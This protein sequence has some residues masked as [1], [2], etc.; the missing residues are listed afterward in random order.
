MVASVA[1]FA[2]TDVDRVIKYAGDVNGVQGYLKLTAFNSTTSMD[3][4]VLSE[5][6]GTTATISWSLGKWNSVDGWPTSATF[7]EQRLLMA[8]T[9]TDPQ[10]W[11]G[12]FL[13]APADFVGDD[14]TANDDSYS[15]KVR[16]EKINVI[17]W[18][19][20]LD[21]LLI[22]TSGEEFK[23]LGPAETTIG[24]VYRPLIQGQTKH[25]TGGVPPLVIEDVLMYMQW[26]DRRLYTLEFK[27]DKDAGRLGGQDLTFISRHLIPSGTKI[28]RLAYEEQPNNVVWAV[29][30]DGVM[31]SMLYF[32]EQEVLG[33]SQHTTVNGLFEEVMC[34]PNVANGVTD[35]YV[36]VKRTV[37]SVTKRY[38]EYFDRTLY[39]DSGLSGTLSP[40]GNVI[41]GLNHLIGEDVV[42]NGDGGA[43]AAV[44]VDAFGQVTMANDATTI[45]AG[46]SFVPTVI[47]LEPYTPSTSVS[48]DQPIGR[49]KKY[50]PLL[51]RTLNTKSLTVNGNTQPARL[52]S[53]LM[54]TPPPGLEIQDWWLSE[55]GYKT[56]SSL[57]ITQPLPL[58][59]HVL[60][61]SGTMTI[62]DK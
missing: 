27:L 18:M 37:N 19:A 9:T 29:R 33:W 17:K 7:H 28:T 12:S 5:L 45:Q 26:G 34:L 46:L 23:V 56:I 50:G 61:I 55:T 38:V 31:L 58:N 60:A 6:S 47:P 10:T 21:T 14:P 32:P 11:W 52:P 35:T 15:Y 62:G 2:A 30:D 20:S 57:T 51:I 24:P 13:N 48:N 36:V 41:N 53:D 39:V 1:T 49:K 59:I 42:T 54:D 4:T 22:G 40:A 44:T 8:S 16:S 3:A 25:G 43:G